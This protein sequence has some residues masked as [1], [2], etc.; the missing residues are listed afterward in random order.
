[1]QLRTERLPSVWKIF[2]KQVN[3]SIDDLLFMEIVNETLLE[4]LIKE[5]Y[6]TQCVDQA[7]PQPTQLSID[8]ENIV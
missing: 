8:E 5:K 3:C 4:N 1:M 2:L 6:A 7:S